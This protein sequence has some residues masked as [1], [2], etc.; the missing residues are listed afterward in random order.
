MTP[1]QAFSKNHIQAVRRL[2]RMG[3]MLIVSISMM[4]TGLAIASDQWHRFA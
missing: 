3:L 1:M 4:I 2:N